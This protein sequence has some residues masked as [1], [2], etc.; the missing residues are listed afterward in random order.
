MPTSYGVLSTYPPT[1]CGLATFSSALVRSLQSPRDV[2]GVVD[3]VD[4]AG[5]PRR[6]E[7]RHQWVRGQEGGAEATASRLNGYDVVVVQHEYGIFGGPDGQDVLDVVRAVT[8]PVIVV[9]HTVLVTPS[10]R[11]KA[12]LD[13]SLIHI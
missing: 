4:V 11:Q 12:I 5:A 3:I 7:V 6:P 10:L 9:L 1:Q 13:L 2:V 8:R